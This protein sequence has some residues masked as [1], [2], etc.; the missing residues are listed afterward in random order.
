MVAI[1]WIISVVNMSMEIR[2]F[3]SE[4]EPR[5]LT[6]LVAVLRSLTLQGYKPHC[7]KSFLDLSSVSLAHECA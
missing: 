3:L 4:L 5:N 2:K 6:G 1:I 7:L